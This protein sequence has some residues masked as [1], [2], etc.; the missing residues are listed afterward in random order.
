MLELIGTPGYEAISRANPLSAR[1]IAGLYGRGVTAPVVA[2]IGVGI[3]ATSLAI[4]RTLGNRGE[5]H[6]FD[7]EPTVRAVASDLLAEG[8]DNIHPHANSD[9]HW[10]SYNWTLG[11]MLLSGMGPTF[12]YVYLDGARTFVTDALAFFLCDRLLRPS[13]LIEF[14]DYDGTYDGS[15]LMVGTRD[16]LMTAEQM[17]TPQVA[18]VVD[19][20]VRDSPGY[21]PVIAN[22]LF[23]KR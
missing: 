5:L 22:R 14:N 3:G 10:D 7:I 2:E 18:M 11:T 13:G 20:F 15:K 9:R 23:R 21:A 4:A 19:L 6:L 8:F 17:A 12:D 1:V 16:Q